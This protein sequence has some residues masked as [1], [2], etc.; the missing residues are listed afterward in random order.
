MIYY[1]YFLM[2]FTEIQTIVTLEQ[3]PSSDHSEFCDR[4][5]VNHIKIEKVFLTKY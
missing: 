2:S 5:N 1:I 4:V 3:A